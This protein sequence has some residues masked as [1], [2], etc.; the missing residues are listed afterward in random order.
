MQLELVPEEEMAIKPKKEDKHRPKGEM[1]EV[2]KDIDTSSVRDSVKQSSGSSSDTS[3]VSG[4]VSNLIVRRVYFPEDIYSNKENQKEFKKI[5]A[6][7][8]LSWHR[9]MMK[10]YTNKNGVTILTGMYV[11]PDQNKKVFCIYEGADKPMTAIVK[12]IGTGGNFL[13]DLNSY[14][15]RV[16]C[17][18]EDKDDMYVNNIL[19][20][21]Q[22]KGEIYVEKI[23]EDT[24]LED[25]QRLFEEKFEKRI[26]DAVEKWIDTHRFYYE[27]RCEFLLWKR[28]LY[29]I[30][31]LRKFRRVEIEDGVR[32]A[33]ENGF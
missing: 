13:I 30:Q 5:L 18:I 12:I 19:L 6:D 15:H 1:V 2:P 33:I 22:E 20:T 3:Q 10:T 23:V 17:T 26:N 24:T 11:S 32:W 31:N 4:R 27:D 29:N 7:Y 25:V 8:G 21:L 9:P 16:G 28:G 14:C